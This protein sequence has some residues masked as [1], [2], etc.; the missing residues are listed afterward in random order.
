MGEGLSLERARQSELQEI[1]FL[2]PNYM[3]EY[4]LRCLFA[5]RRVL[6][7][8]LIM[9]GRGYAR[10]VPSAK[11]GGVLLVVDGTCKEQAGGSEIFT[12]MIQLT[13]EIQEFRR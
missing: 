5:P 13:L 3:C 7:D 4:Q 2:R 9:A 6:A 1:V 11:R 10:G 8:G 12:G